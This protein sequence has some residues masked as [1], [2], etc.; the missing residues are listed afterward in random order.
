[1]AGEIRYG[2][3]LWMRDQASGGLDKVAGRLKKIGD[4]T[5]TASRTARRGLIAM[6][7][8]LAA[9]TYAA[10]NQQKADR[11][12]ADTLK[13]TGQYSEEMYLK[14]KALA[15]EMQNLTVYGDEAVQMLEAQALNLGITADGLDEAVRGAIGLS[16]ALDMDLSTALRYTALALQGEFTVLQRYVPELRKAETESEK[17]A[18]VQKL[19]AA[20]FEQAKGQAEELG[21]RLKQVR[22]RF[23]DLLETI[24]MVIFGTEDWGDTLRVIQERLKRA[25]DWIKGLTAEEIEQIKKTA[26]L[27]A[28]VTALVAILSPLAFAL[29]AVVSGLAAI[30]SPAGIVVGLLAAI[31]AATLVVTDAL[32]VTDTGV[33]KLLTSMKPLD[34]FWTELAAGMLIAAD[35]IKRAVAE[36]VDTARLAELGIQRLRGFAP[37]RGG[38][39]KIRALEAWGSGRTIVEPEERIRDLQRARHEAGA[40]RARSTAE[41][42]A[43]VALLWQRFRERH[44]PKPAAPSGKGGALAP[45]LAGGEPAAVAGAVTSLGEELIP[46]LKGILD[47]Q[48]VTEEELGRLQKQVKKLATARR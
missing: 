44:K 40:D 41:S 18:I 36:I 47:D 37:G 35:M 1:M 25:I 2:I 12:L 22:N 3:L 29:G 17:L 48:Q 27:V 7:G 31:A 20:G 38:G 13:T 34:E 42:D 19:M 11:K 26:L 32:G 8:G 9:V 28:G 33:L 16:E 45:G 15:G 4:Q 24:G 39:K 10:A 14:L 30:A 43:A 5:R 46:L 23:G 21:G 6:A